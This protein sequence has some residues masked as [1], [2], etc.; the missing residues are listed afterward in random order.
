[1]YLP[2]ECKGWFVYQSKFVLLQ[3]ELSDFSYFNY[4]QNQIKGIKYNHT[5][6]RNN[7]NSV[8]IIFHLLFW[9]SQTTQQNSHV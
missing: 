7:Y 2:D 5:S 8:R 3:S 4:E 6:N 1:M 9:P